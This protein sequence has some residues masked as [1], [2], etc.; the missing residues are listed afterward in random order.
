MTKKF[1]HILI[2][3]GLGAHGFIHVVETIINIYES[4]Y[5]SA[6]FS[7]LAGFFMVAGALINPDHHEEENQLEDK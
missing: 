3:W 1:A 5:I 7:L 2:R 6:F 4:A